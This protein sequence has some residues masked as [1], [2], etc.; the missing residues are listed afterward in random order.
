[1]QR[2]VCAI[3]VSVSVVLLASG[4][5]QMT[6]HSNTMIFG[7]NTQ[8]GISA[9]TDATAVPSVN[10]GYR[11]QEAVV[12]PLIANKADADGKLVPQ[13]CRDGN[14]EGCLLTGKSDGGDPK[15]TA[16]DTYSVLASF[17]ATFGGG[18]DASGASASGGLAQYFA[19]GLAARKLA[20][21]GGAAL[22]ATGKAAEEQAKYSTALYS[23]SDPRVKA[24]TAALEKKVA[25]NRDVA[26]AYAKGLPDD[27]LAAKLKE[28]AKTAG[29]S[30]DFF[31]D[32]QEV[33]T[34][35]E[36]LSYINGPF[37]ADNDEALATA[38]HQLKGGD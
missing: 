4:C 25:S 33:T 34:K 5:T 12:M 36:L 7:T 15:L 24:A 3:A 16:S 21:V 30:E 6:R 29:L 22:V 2:T 8:F 38:A 17:G 37:F 28:W 1:M 26:L 35:D 18:A 27:Q 10:V 19:T 23:A 14:A 11:R 32:V 31:S 9:G 13:D 20:E